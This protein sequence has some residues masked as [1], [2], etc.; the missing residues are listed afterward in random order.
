VGF[1]RRVVRKSLRRATP[2]PVR[3]AMHPA[4]TVR[5]AVT[6]QPV[7]QVSR[8]AYTVRHPVG[9]AENKAIGAVLY[10]RTGIGRSGGLS[11][12]LSLLRRRE[13]SGRRA[14]VPTRWPNV[15]PS[16]GAGR[17]NVVQRPSI[18]R[19]APEQQ[20][21]QRRVPLSPEAKSRQLA[22]QEYCIAWTEWE[23]A[24]PTVRGPEPQWIAQDSDLEG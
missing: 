20:A 6:P 11:F 18:A 14:P 10:P 19:Q 24:N 4:R 13:Q 7:R 8:A 3:R 17:P 23:K 12:W 1:A 15:D 9:A 5:N 21:R 16:G 2:R 22:Y